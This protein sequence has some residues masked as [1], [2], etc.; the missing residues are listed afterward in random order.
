MQE[1]VRQAMQQGAL[2]V[3]SSLSGPPGSWIDTATLVSMC[4]V[5]GEYG[6]IYSTHM[7]TEGKGVFESVAEAIDIG[8][9]AGVPVDIIHLKIADH[10]LW[11]QMPELVASIAQARA[12]GQDVTANVYPYRAGQNN[13]A[14]IIPPWAHD[15]GAA[16]MLQR[17]KDP[18]L[19]DR[20]VNEIEHGIPGSN[21]YDHYTAT[22]SWEGMLLVSL[23]NP[24]YKKFEGRRMNEVIAALGGKPLDV[25]FR[26]LEDNGGSVP[27]I[28][29]H[30]DENDMRYA[31]KQPFV[32]I[33]SDGTAIATTGPTAE[34][35]PHPR[36]YGTF[37]RVLGRYVRD[38][39][40]LTLEDAIRKMTSA[41]AAKIHV[42]DRGLLRAG[43]WAD[44][45]VFDPATIIDNATWEQPHQYATGVRFVFVNGK[46]VLDG[47][48]H[49][50][51]RPGTILYGPGK[52]GS[53]NQARSDRA[54]AEWVIRQG[55]NVRIAGH[56]GLVRDATE[57]PTGDITVL[58]V[59]L[60]GTII[61][62]KDLKRVGDLS[63][64]RE[65]L[66]PAPSFNPGAGST[67]DA[68]EEF[69]S[70]AN[71]HHLEKLW[72]SLHFLTD[73][74]VED[75]GLAHLKNLTQ[76]RELRLVQTKV[77]GSSLAPFVNL[78]AL[79]LGETPFRDDGM[80][81]LR[82]MT[83]LKILSLRNTLV[84][85]A[86]LKNLA[87]LKDL[88]SLDLYGI[89]VTDAGL[90]SLSGLTKLRALNLLGAAV[91]D[92]SAP[93]L[94]RWEISRANIPQFHH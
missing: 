78:R 75:K 89:K 67:L 22:G 44:I 71:L 51:A 50:G 33:G 57:L 63:E 43:M 30:H 45:T 73:I 46:L 77:R 7:R 9:R 49:T 19:H 84:T 72:F 60:I 92:D 17:L 65:L 93:V 61:D 18:A 27:T 70:L 23:S 28:Y 52:L 37:P 74:H 80:Q 69:A 62:P 11:G 88:E 47:G 58:A 48:E 25:L 86:G 41:N 13:L 8:R 16:A 39:K 38:E 14:T 54:A 1:L 36:Y 53:D 64:V 76:L 94:A 40:V 82:G 90:Q 34:G 20:L 35:H 29:F 42:Y 32:S 15:G 59:D 3:A 83:H 2:G 55:G 56:N 5:A 91:T 24:T 21:W 12:N 79:D 66:L 26:I 68:N 87:D 81:Y 31:L 4:K 6:G 85:D 10:E